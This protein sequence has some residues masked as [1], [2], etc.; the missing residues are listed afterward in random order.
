MLQ[1]RFLRFGGVTIIDLIFIRIG[2]ESD[3]VSGAKRSE[4]THSLHPR[5]QHSMVW[6]STSIPLDPDLDTASVFIAGAPTRSQSQCL[7]LSSGQGTHGLF[8][9]YC[10]LLEGAP[11]GEGPRL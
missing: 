10:S 6:I 7:Q 3:W 8:F 2:Q 5:E 4:E 1:Q 11:L 9:L